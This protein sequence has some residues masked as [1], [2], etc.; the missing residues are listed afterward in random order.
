M[1]QLVLIISGVL[2]LIFMHRILY[3]LTTSK[4]ENIKITQKYMIKINDEIIYKIFDENKMEY[5]LIEDALISKKRCK[6]IFNQIEENENYDIQYYGLHL[7]AININYRII[8]IAFNVN[9]TPKEFSFS[10][11]N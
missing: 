11:K 7:P 1:I 2:F 4:K 9:D 8:D 5:I 6:E 3:Y 10:T